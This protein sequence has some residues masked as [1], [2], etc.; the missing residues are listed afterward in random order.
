MGSILRSEKTEG[1][2]FLP[3]SIK[4]YHHNH[5]DER[6]NKVKTQIKKVLNDLPGE[7]DVDYVDDDDD[8]APV[9]L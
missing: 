8:D 1:N 4:K 2:S 3:P 9:V 6:N 7:D 5:S